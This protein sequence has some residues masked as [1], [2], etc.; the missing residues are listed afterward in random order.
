MMNVLCICVFMQFLIQDRLISM[1]LD[2]DNEVALQTMKLVILISK[3]VFLSWFSKHPLDFFWQEL[4]CLSSDPLM[5]YWLLR[6]TNSSFSLFTHH[7]ALLRPPQ[8]SWSS[9]GIEKWI[10]WSKQINQMMCDFTKATHIKIN[11]QESLIN[12]YSSLICWFAVCNILLGC[13][14]SLSESSGPVL[15]SP[16]KK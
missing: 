11:L 5:M 15:L 3:W 6:T 2:K 8:E 9:Q 10:L 14:R 1:T 12:I 7:S 4:T 13:C 16:K